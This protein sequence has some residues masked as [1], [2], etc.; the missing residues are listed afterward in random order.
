MVQ[1]SHLSFILFDIGT[2]IQT[3]P[4]GNHKCVTG[5][6][7][8][9]PTECPLVTSIVSLS[10]TIAIDIQSSFVSPTTSTKFISAT[11]H[12]NT[13]ILLSSGLLSTVIHNLQSSSAFIP[14][15]ISIEP[16]TT[17]HSYQTSVIQTT[18]T[19]SVKTPPTDDQKPDEESNKLLYLLIILPF[20]VALI[21]ILVGWKYRQN[22]RS[23][24]YRVT[25][26]G[27]HYHDASRNREMH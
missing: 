13:Y 21:I 4:E 9:N 12:S 18:P 8:N 3:C 5:E 26:R 16:T 2:F 27:K 1:F 15:T 20:V 10:S 7:V 19:N 22:M 25:R 23:M 11:S 14:S 24:I 6:C 17:H